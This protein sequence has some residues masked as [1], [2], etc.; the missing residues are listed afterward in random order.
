MKNFT[1]QKN[2]TEKIQVSEKEYKDNKY[3]DVRIWYLD[4]KS[5]EYK[6]TKKGVSFTEEHWADFIDKLN[7]SETE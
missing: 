3:I 1:I 5:G 2:P 7:E 4:E 6:P